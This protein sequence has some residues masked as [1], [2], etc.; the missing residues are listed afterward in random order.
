MESIKLYAFNTLVIMLS[1]SNI[2]NALKIILLI[3]SIVYTGFKIKESW[4]ARK[5]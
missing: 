4:D 1:F 3:L 2:E 5:K